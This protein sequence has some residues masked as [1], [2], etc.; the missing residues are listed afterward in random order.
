MF[1]ID[2]VPCFNVFS[3]KLSVIFTSLYVFIKLLEINGNK[4]KIAWI[5]KNVLD[6][7]AR[8][9]KSLKSTVSTDIQ[10]AQFN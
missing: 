7:F 6:F 1:R 8:Q 9:H 4:S 2:Q 3:V 10:R 5:E